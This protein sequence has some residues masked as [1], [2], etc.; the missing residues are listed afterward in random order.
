MVAESG[1]L[2]V[3]PGQ[4]LMITLTAPGDDQHVMPSG[5]VCPCTRP[6]GVYLPEFNATITARTNRFLEAL[7]RGEAS[8]LVRGRRRH[9]DLEYFNAR[10]TQERLALHDH[11]LIRRTDG[12]ALQLRTSDVRALAIK[13]GFGHSVKVRVVGLGKHGGS[14]ARTAGGAAAYCAKYVSKTADVRPD[15]PWS[16]PRRQWRTW[17]CSRRWGQ[18]M[19]A[20]REAARKH[21]READRQ[22]AE[23]CA[24]GQGAQPGGCRVPP[25]NA[26]PERY[27][28]SSCHGPPE[29]ADIGRLIS[30]FPG[31]EIVNGE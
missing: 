8:P 4:A 10:E 9:L 7:R 27:A 23:A 29:R 24:P 15:V 22:A 31:S 28:S 19:K 18:S 5:E 20:L 2:L 6:G 25:F 21:A 30:A 26:L 1:L 14:K 13:H 3:R 17:T 11:M 12:K 16:G